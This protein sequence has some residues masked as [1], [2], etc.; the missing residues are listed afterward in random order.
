MFKARPFKVLST[1][2][3][4]VFNTSSCIGL[5]LVTVFNARFVSLTIISKAPPIQGLIGGKNFHAMF[6]NANSFAMR[7][8]LTFCRDY[9]SSFLTPTKFDLL[10]HQIISGSPLPAMNRRTV[11]EKLSI[12]ISIE[13]SKCTALVVRQASKLCLFI[14]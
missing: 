12:V 5:S 3:R 9:F 14:I 2:I 13:S 11:I 1:S 10:S 8:C 7:S 6:R 4:N